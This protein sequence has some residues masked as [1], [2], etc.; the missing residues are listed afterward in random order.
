MTRSPMAH[1]FCS[2]CALY[3]ARRLTYFLYCGCFTNRWTTTTTVFSILLLTTT[4]SRTFV[5]PRIARTSSAAGA[6][7]PLGLNRLHPRQVAARPHQRRRALELIGAAAQPEAEN[8]LA[9]L[10]LFHRQLLIVQ[11]AQLPNPHG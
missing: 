2:S 3:L 6:A 10:F 7:R 1:R 5:L 9:Q 8:R 4:P 11:V